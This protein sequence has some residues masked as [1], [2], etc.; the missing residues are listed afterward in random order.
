M[1]KRP[2]TDHPIAP[3]DIAYEDGYDLIR[4]FL[5]RP[6][7]PFH[8]SKLQPH[9]FSVS[10]ISRQPKYQSNRKLGIEIFQPTL[11]CLEVLREGLGQEVGVDIVYA[12][13]GRDVTH[14][15]KA[16]IKHLEAAFLECAEI[17][18]FPRPSS[19]S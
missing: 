1:K 18:I 19:A 17:P 8:V 3:S 10:R 5:D 14:S 2:F 4:L 13:I 16:V 11:K 15:D 6:E 12:E 9:C 7:L